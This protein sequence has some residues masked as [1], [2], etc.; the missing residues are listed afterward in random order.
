MG[1]TKKKAKSILDPS[2]GGLDVG[3]LID[4]GGKV[5]EKLTGSKV[6]RKLA[7]PAGVIPE[8]PEPAIKAAEESAKKAQEEI[9]R[10][11]QREKARLAEEEDVIERKRAKGRGAGRSLLVATSPTGRATTLG[12]L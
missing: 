7:D 4:P 3:S 6:G 5:V 2:G 8:D 1:N 9:A 10:Q 11:K 12:G